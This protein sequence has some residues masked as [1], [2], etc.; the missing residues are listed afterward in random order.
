MALQ[1]KQVQGMIVDSIFGLQSQAGMGQVTLANPHRDLLQAQ[2]MASNFL[3]PNP[4]GGGPKLKMG[5]S[6]GKVSRAEEQVR[7]QPFKLVDHLSQP[8]FS[9]EPMY[10]RPH[11]I[12][13]NSKPM[14]PDTFTPSRDELVFYKKGDPLSNRVMKVDYMMVQYNAMSIVNPA[15]W[16]LLAIAYQEDLKK[17]NPTAFA[18]LTPGDMMA[19]WVVDGIVEQNGLGIDSPMSV[20]STRT[21]QPICVISKGLVAVK[22]YWPHAEPGDELWI[23]VKKYE[24]NPNFQLNTSQNGSANGAGV[25]R[26]KRELTGNYDPIQM[27]F[28]CKRQ[29]GPLDPEVY[30]YLGDDGATRYDAW[31]V[32]LGVVGFAP[33]GAATFD[34]SY[35]SHDYNDAFKGHAYVD[36][37]EGETRN[38]FTPLRFYLD[39]SAGLMPF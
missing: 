32:C 25:R 13:R 26:L 9:S 11:P 24:Y 30:E 16:N 8:L 27:G 19:Q 39:H 33:I 28:Y 7:P 23:V 20:K 10:N 18:E 21:N 4:L 22:S 31:T 2:S 14:A 35:R 36:S 1:G 17:N 29:G 6:V 5:G 34:Q 15:Q 12:T 38:N 3:Q 37:T